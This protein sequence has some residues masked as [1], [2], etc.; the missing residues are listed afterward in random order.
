MRVRVRLR[1]EGGAFRQPYGQAHSATGD[2]HLT[3]RTA[4]GRKVAMLHLLGADRQWP[5]LFDPRLIALGAREFSFIGFER[6]ER[7]WVLQ[8]WDCELL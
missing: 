4:E 3:H 1:R 8:Q 2:L 7:A 5:S 6:H